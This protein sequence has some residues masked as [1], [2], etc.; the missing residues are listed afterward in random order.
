M[1]ARTIVDENSTDCGGKK[2]GENSIDFVEN[3]TIY[4]CFLHFA[5]QFSATRFHDF[6]NPKIS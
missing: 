4:G 3:L 6:W 5:F 2:V 1:H